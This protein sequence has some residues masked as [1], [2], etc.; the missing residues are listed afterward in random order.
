VNA[1]V[2]LHPA[3][4]VARVATTTPLLR[5]EITR[6]LGREVALATALTAVGAAVV[7]PSAL[8]PPGPHQHDGLTLSFWRHVEVLPERPSAAEAGAALGELHDALAGLPS[9]WAGSPL[10]TPLDD[11]AVFAVRGAELGAD[12]ALVDRTAE[13]VARLRPLL[14]GPGTTLH[15]DTH[16]GNLLR[17]RDGWV[18]ADLEDTSRG[19]LAWD[20]S[21]LRRTGRLDGRAALDALPNAPSDA[22]LAPFLSLRAL[23]AAA[24]WYVH[25]VRV[26]ADLAAARDQHRAA[27]DE[28]SAVLG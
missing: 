2:H 7:G 18:W 16:P 26:P 9:L 1:V 24:W 17:T 12:P 22:E 25:A 15:G 8:L 21:C 4:V 11:L 13:L 19:P 20:L 27:V 5:P 14:T 6:P 3:P 23:H 10:D 28:V